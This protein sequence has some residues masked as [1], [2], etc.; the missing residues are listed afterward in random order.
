V[1]SPGITWQILDLCVG[2]IACPTKMRQ[3]RRGPGSSSR[4]AGRWGKNKE[5]KKTVIVYTIASL[6]A[7]VYNGKYY[8]NYMYFGILLIIWFWQMATL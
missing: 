7:L 4:M 8:G 1:V 2:S 3:N 5:L 6:M